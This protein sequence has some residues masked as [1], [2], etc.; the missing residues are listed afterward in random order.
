MAL[1]KL[2]IVSRTYQHVSR[3]RQ[4]LAALVRYGFGDLVDRLHISH[5]LE[6]GLHLVGRRGDERVAAH[7]RPQR[8]RM[9]LEELGP[10]FVKLGQVASTRPDLFEP[11]FIAEL[12]KLCDDV[13][14]FE[15]AEVRRIVESELGRPL[16]ELFAHFDPQ[17]LAAASIGQVHRARLAD[18]AQVVVKVQRPGIHPVIRVDLEILEHLAG[19]I[20]QHVEE[21][22]SL[23]PRQIVREFARVIE[24]ELDYEIERANLEH[25]ARIFADDPT[26]HVPRVFRELSTSLVLTMEYVEGLNPLDEQALEAAGLDRKLLARRGAH[27]ILRQIFEEGFFHAD[28]HPGNML[29]LPDN[30]VGYLDFGMMGRLD[31]RQREEMAELIYGM[32]R[33]DAERTTAALL[34]ITEHE[35]DEELDR[36]ALVRDIAGLLDLQVGTELGRIRIDDLTHRLLRLVSRHHLRIP[37]ELVTMLK[38]LATVEGIGAALDPQLNMIELA[39]P[40]V[41]WVLLARYSPTRLAGELF[42]TSGD[43]YD[44][45][46]E[47]PGGVR[48]LLKLAKRGGV[49]IDVEHRGFDKMIETH[50]RVSNRISFALVVAALIVGS[51]LLVASHMP[52]MVYGIP[53]IGLAGFVAAGIMGFLLLWSIIRHGRM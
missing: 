37:P 21:A 6:L 7:T 36:R 11:E 2:G 32:S 47:L 22:R 4:I 45:L 44:L 19:L 17:P 29:A 46:H 40:Y 42:Q 26:V 9:L 25:F 35:D 34:R 12:E 23:R 49:R 8:V 16:E 39:T 18:G 33:F 10:T 20:E 41:R 43:I 38:A 48:E 24:Q 30:V 52:P 5:Y 3:Y 53:V 51:S 1:R 15:F 28:P 14:P 13:P 50:Q 31:R 27:S